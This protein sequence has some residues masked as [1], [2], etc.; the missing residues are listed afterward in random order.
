MDKIHYT[1]CLVLKQLSMLLLLTVITATANANTYYVSPSGSNTS[2]YDTWAKAANLVTTA[3]TAGNNATGPHTVYIAPG[4]YAGKL[5]LSNVKWVNGTIVGVSASGSTSPATKGQVIIDGGAANGASVTREGVT[6]SNLSFTT[7]TTGAYDGIYIE[8]AGFTGN[9]LYVYNVSRYLVHCLTGGS[10]FKFNRCRFEGNNGVN[11]VYIEGTSGGTFNYCIFRNSTTNLLGGGNAT[12]AGLYILGSGNTYLNNCNI[13]GVRQYGV[14]CNT[15]G[16]LIITNCIIMGNI[17]V[18]VRRLAGTCITQNCMLVGSWSANDATLLGRQVNGTVTTTN[19]ITSAIVPKFVHN[20][21]TGYIIPTIDD[22]LKDTYNFADSIETVL[23]ARGIKGTWF[24]SLDS[25]AAYLPPIKAMSDGYWTGTRNLEIAYHS[26]GHT[27]LAAT[28]GTTIFTVTKNSGTININRATDTITLSGGT[29]ISPYKTLNLNTIRK[30]LTDGGA[31]LTAIPDTLSGTSLGESISDSGGDQST[32]SGYAITIYIPSDPTAGGYLK[33][34]IIDGKA[35]MESSS[36]LNHPI[37]DFASPR[38]SWNENVSI[39][40]VAAGFAGLRNT[41]SLNNTY[42]LNNID[43]QKQMCL[44]VIYWKNSDPAVQAEFVRWICEAVEQYGLIVYLLSHNS[45]DATVAQYSACIDQIRSEYPDIKVCSM[46]EAM[47][48]I[49]SSGTWTTSDNRKYNR[50]WTDEA[51]FHLQS[52]SP[53]IDKGINVSLT[54]DYEGNPI[55]GTPDIGAYEYQPSSFTITA[56]VDSNGTITPSGSISIAQ[57]GSQLFTITPLSGF[58]ISD[59]LVDGVSVGTDSTYTFT[60]ITANHSIH[61][62]FAPMV[63]TIL[64][65]ADSTGT[66][67]PSDSV[68]VAQGGTQLFTITPHT[69]FRISDVLVD[70]VSV[71]TDSTYTFTNVTANH[72][73]HARFAPSVHYTILATA[74][75]TGTISPSDSVSVIEGGMKLFTI[76]PHTGFRISDVL[77]D[78]VSVGTDSTYTFTNVTANHTIHARFAPSVYYTILATADSTGT[79]SPSDSVSVAQ[80][81]TQL[82]TITPH[83]GFRISDV[84][85]DGVSV[86]TDSTY[87][88][89]NVTANHTIHA[90]FAPS[91]YYTIL[92]TADSTGTI[93]PSDSVSVIEG[94]MKLFT[95]TPHTGFRISDILVD[96]VSV[97]TD[98]TYTFTNVTANH[99]IHARFAP[100]VYYTI[101]ATA[102]STGTISPSDSVSVAQGGT[103]LFTI[104]PHTGF[105]ISDVFVDSVSVGADSTYTFTNVTAN[106]TIHAQFSETY[107]AW[108]KVNYTITATADSTGIITPSGSVV[109][110]QGGA[111]FFAITPHSG[112]QVSDVF[113]DGISVG[114]VSTY[115]F[116]NVTANHTIHAMF[117]SNHYSGIGS[118]NFRIPVQAGTFTV[119]G[120]KLRIKLEA[121]STTNLTIIRACI[122]Q[123]AASGDNYDMEP[124]TIK[125]ITFNHGAPSDSLSSG[126][127]VYSDWILYNYDK[128][129][130]YI[131]SLGT[132]GGYK[133]WANSGYGAY[134]KQNA[135]INANISDV[136]EY[137]TS[138]AVYVLERL[139]ISTN[140]YGVGKIVGSDM[141]IATKIFSGE[142]LPDESDVVDTS[143]QNMGC[144]PNPFNG[145]TTIRFMLPFGDAV[146]LNIYNIMGQKVSDLVTGNLP[147]GQHNVS[148]NGKSNEGNNVASGVYFARLESCK[149]VSTIRISYIK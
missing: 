44:G 141:G 130:D 63:Y 20:Q 92:A 84:L 125:D 16:S 143:E 121:S 45:H 56:S 82:F 117:V 66:I 127:T 3:I 21:R 90:R 13:L 9:N 17:G 132:S 122:G 107:G 24:V 29:T 67:S 60:N 4:T 23:R 105:R 95:I 34:E 94:G 15:T 134:F 148:W 99:T 75:S 49:R 39:T 64:A 139:E 31:T 48:D 35:M 6:L 83:T 108:N 27:N 53:A 2:P 126:T 135:Q 12:S 87:T 7:Q 36:F 1:W 91:V 77:V 81:G 133:T 46:H 25:L 114:G 28:N 86:G 72:T 5:M 33:S 37:F 51:D 96:G 115:T 145:F 19:N 100:S 88:F 69:G 112:Y 89:T 146:R 57:G 42:Y 52:N 79:I 59:V 62:R 70:G 140:T 149:K 111:Q 128:S 65:T 104:T 14:C 129:K 98:S 123:R 30:A 101:L 11:G 22:M 137:T 109:I 138:N 41:S 38:G 118:Y 78:G 106:H 54:E 43:L 74:D 26:I 110:T 80:G 18:P 71:G 32:T 113:V 131:I 76:T 144:Y 85:V 116:T 47:N 102:D 73:I 58:R 124:G 142:T 68:S 93:S 61:A 40:S 147:A 119:N 55:Y 103:Q 120:N 8:G 97:G 50:T 136:S 10:T